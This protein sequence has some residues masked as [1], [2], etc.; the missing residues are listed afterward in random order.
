MTIGI[1]GAGMIGAT[2][3]KQ[4]SDAGYRVII[5]Y[6][7]N[8]ERLHTLAKTLGENVEVGTVED[9]LIK[10]NV[11]ILS[12]KLVNIEDA[13]KQMKS[14]NQ[15]I[16]IDTSNPFGVT[17]PAGVTAAAYT[18][19]LFPGTRLVKAFNTLHYTALATLNTSNPK[20]VIPVC[21]DD[22]EAKAICKI[23]VTAIGYE[24]YDTG[25]LANVT[26][27]EPGGF[28]FNKPMTLEDTKSFKP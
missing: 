11:T 2:L 7:R 18:Q 19:S 26:V 27:Q 20:T 14:F 22:E 15:K 13:K 8:I 10:T 28:F 16:I 1:I 4:F 24:P 6:S 5:S 23:M 3:A 25:T 21:S 12:V 9:A 17:L